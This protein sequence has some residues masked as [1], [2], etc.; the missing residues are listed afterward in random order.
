[1]EGVSGNMKPK[2]VLIMNPQPKYKHAE[3]VELITIHNGEMCFVAN[4]ILICHCGKCT[5][6]EYK[7]S[8]DSFINY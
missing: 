6:E 3:K 1:M 2:T 8:K 4:G 5:L 7:L